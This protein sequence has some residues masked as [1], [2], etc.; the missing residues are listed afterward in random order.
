MPDADDS[1]ES[2]TDP[3]DH[4]RTTDIEPL[5]ERYPELAPEPAEDLFERLVISVVNQLLSTEAARTIRE[6]LFEAV[7]VT[8][9]GVLAAE[10]ATM[11]EAGLSPQKVEYVQN[12]A[13]WFLTVEPTHERFATMTDA[14][15]IAELTD[16]KGVGDWTA[17][18]FLMFGLGRSDVF[19]VED[20]AI[21]RG[22][23][24]LYGL[25]SRGEMREKARNWAPYRSYGSLYVWQHYV[26][27]N[28]DVDEPVAD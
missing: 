19:P 11:R 1:T 13:E 2:P 28:S 5:V 6:R 22:M 10:E 16:L 15:V 4:L 7:E 8:P 20:L 14:E 27:E 25:D 9:E 18:M 26:D 17:K 23:E 3:Y 12:I 24:D 21:R